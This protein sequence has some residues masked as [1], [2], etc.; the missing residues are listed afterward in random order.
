MSNG[1][2]TQVGRIDAL[3]KQREHPQKVQ[4]LSIGVQTQSGLDFA[5]S[6]PKPARE[7]VIGDGPIQ[8]RMVLTQ[9]AQVAVIE[10]CTDPELIGDVGR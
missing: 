3:R 10:L 7:T 4:I 5:A 9:L 8:R 6:N 2:I 1:R